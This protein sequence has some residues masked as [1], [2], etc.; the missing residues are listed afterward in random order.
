MKWRVKKKQIRRDLDC[1][2]DKIPSAFTG[3]ADREAWIRD[4]IKNHPALKRKVQ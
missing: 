2:A 4:I 1:I 3:K